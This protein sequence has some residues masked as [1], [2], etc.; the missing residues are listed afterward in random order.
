ME[1]YIMR[2]LFC[3]LPALPLPVILLYFCLEDCG[4]FIPIFLF[5]V[6]FCFSWQ[7]TE[8]RPERGDKCD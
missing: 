8:C 7:M 5:I 6:L 2:I 1:K 3:L 4:G